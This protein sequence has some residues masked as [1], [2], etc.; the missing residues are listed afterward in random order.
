MIS[1]A[2]AMQQEQIKELLANVDEDGITYSFKEKKG[3]K[4]Y[5]NVTGDVNEAV[6]KAKALIKAQPWG[7]VLYF[8][9]LPE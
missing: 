9:I 5:F 3:I 7:S 4:L 2:S 8:Q 1:I 6:A